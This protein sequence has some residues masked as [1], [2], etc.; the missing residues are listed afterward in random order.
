[1]LNRIIYILVIAFIGI[2]FFGIDTDNP[3]ID[4][5]ND[6]FNKLKVS[7]ETQQLIKSACYDCHS[8]ETVFPKYAYMQPVGWLLKDHIDDGRKHLNFSE[9]NTYEKKKKDHKM[10]ECVEMLKKGEMPLKGYT[11]LHP[12]AVMDDSQ[13]EELMAFFKKMM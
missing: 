6:F 9:W 1:M 8:N 13:K 12:E 10:E 7:E 5:R 2:Q 3:P 4:E 11:L